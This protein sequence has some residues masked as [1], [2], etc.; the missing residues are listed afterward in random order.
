MDGGKSY[1]GSGQ[2]LN[3]EGQDRLTSPMI[4]R[5]YRLN[6]WLSISAQGHLAFGHGVAQ[7]VQ[8]SERV[9]FHMGSCLPGMPR[10][11][12]NPCPRWTRMI[13]QPQP[14]IEVCAAIPDLRR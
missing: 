12:Q 4:A 13:A 7:Q 14:R 6:H 10:M 8:T 3:I 5:V 2:A 1:E 9:L 11:N